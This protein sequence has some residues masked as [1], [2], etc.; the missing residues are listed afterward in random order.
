M[1]KQLIIVLI[2]FTVMVPVLCRANKPLHSIS[3]TAYDFVFETLEGQPFKLADYRGKVL[4]IV[5]T[6]SHCGF[7]PQYGALQQLYHDLH[8]RGLEIIGIPSTDFGHQEFDKS[9]EIKTFTHDKFH[10]QF[11]LTGLTNVKGKH[12]HPFYLWAAKQ[13]GILGTPKWNFHKYLIDRQGYLV[14]WFPSY[15]TPRSEKV[16]KAIEI[17]LQKN[18]I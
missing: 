7:T 6:A 8:P 9:T 5:N 15:T 13:V 16:L 17:E 4:L 18:S 3:G 14:A 11:P 2:V 12:A 1:F 10:I